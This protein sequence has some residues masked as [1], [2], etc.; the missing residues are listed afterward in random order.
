MFEMEFEGLLV[1][2]RKSCVAL[3]HSAIKFNNSKKGE[4]NVI[5]RAISK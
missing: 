5:V 3:L 1:L 2:G 4:F